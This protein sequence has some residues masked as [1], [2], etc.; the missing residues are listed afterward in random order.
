MIGLRRSGPAAKQRF[1]GSNTH[2]VMPGLV[3]GIH[4]SRH[5]AAKTVDGRDKPGHDGTEMRSLNCGTIK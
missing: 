5:L 3:P 2:P 4:V 1:I